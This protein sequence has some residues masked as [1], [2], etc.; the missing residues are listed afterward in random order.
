MD[1][2]A[3]WQRLVEAYALRYWTEAKEA[4]VDLL[5]WLRG[6]GFP[7]ETQTIHPMDDEWNRTMAEAACRFVILKCGS[8]TT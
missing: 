1:P 5:V 4:A 8:Q 7:P 3:T 6:G 2:Q